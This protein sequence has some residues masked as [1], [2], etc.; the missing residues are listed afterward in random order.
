[1]RSVIDTYRDLARFRI[2]TFDS[3]KTKRAKKLVFR[4]IDRS[5]ARIA[6]SIQ[7][8]YT[9]KNQAD[10]WGDLY[11]PYPYFEVTRSEIHS[12]VDVYVRIRRG[13]FFIDINEDS[14]PTLLMW[15]NKWRVRKPETMEEY[16][17]F[18]FNLQW[19]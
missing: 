11:R 15:C 10:S 7:R 6:N 3:I 2:N 4:D 14:L 13:E 8:G 19:W 1:M 12:Q 16:E 18:E 5:L 17:N 9:L